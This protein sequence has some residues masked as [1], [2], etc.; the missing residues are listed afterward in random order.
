MEK[1]G[2]KS[3][4]N[5][6][7]KIGLIF[8]WDLEKAKTNKD[9]HGIS[10][11]EATSLFM[12]ENAFVIYDVKHSKVEK[13]FWRIAKTETNKVLLVVYT[14]RELENGKESIRIISARQASRKER[15]TYSRL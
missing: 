5:V 4:I 9:K 7:T 14:K 15:K 13:R 10:F 12:D 2:Q 6:Y 8:S 3:R 1:S 11:E